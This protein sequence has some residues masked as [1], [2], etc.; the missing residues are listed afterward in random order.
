MSVQDFNPVVIL[1]RVNECIP[2]QSHE[3]FPLD[4]SSTLLHSTPLRRLDPI[5]PFHHSALLSLRH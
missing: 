4:V 2:S 1:T 5:A 3:R